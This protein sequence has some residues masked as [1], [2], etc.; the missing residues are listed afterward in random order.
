MNSRKLSVHI[1]STSPTEPSPQLSSQ[2]QSWVLTYLCP[3]V[4]I[5]YPSDCSM[6]Q[7]L[8]AAHSPSYLGGWSRGFIWPHPKQNS[9]TCHFAFYFSPFCLLIDWLIEAESLYVALSSLCLTDLPAFAYG[10][11]AMTVGTTTPAT[12]SNGQVKLIKG[13]QG[14]GCLVSNSLFLRQDL[15]LQA[16]TTGMYHY[17]QLR[18]HFLKG[19]FFHR[20]WIFYD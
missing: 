19:F 8:G 4:L 12:F 10:V 7:A 5:T 18:F 11:L 13:C 20:I 14:F 3:M 16:R 15:Q 2:T 9:E 17:T 1:A 6:G